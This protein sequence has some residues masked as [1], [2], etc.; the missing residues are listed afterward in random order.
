MND[1]IFL[2]NYYDGGFLE[3]FWNL[4]GEVVMQEKPPAAMK[5]ELRHCAS[6]SMHIFVGGSCPA[7][8]SGV[9][10]PARLFRGDLDDVA[11][12]PFELVAV[13]IRGLMRGALPESL[14]SATRIV[15]VTAPILTCIDIEAGGRFNGAF[16]V[17]WECHFGWN[18]F[19]SFADGRI[20]NPETGKCMTPEFSP[21]T[22]AT[23]LTLN[24]CSRERTQQF[25]YDDA[26]ASFRHLD[27]GNCITIGGPSIA[28]GAPVVLEPC[29]N[30]V[31]ENQKL[32]AEGSTSTF[33]N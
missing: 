23:D 17:V 25:A 22:G 18:Q 9:N 14:S 30:G 32:V 15:A 28:N 12:F 2:N 6:A 10:A 27:S 31:A 1:F 5:A 21:R 29:P 19:W 33:H 16:L 3:F 11:I 26:A 8:G 24:D 7:I 4:D 20:S 13:Q